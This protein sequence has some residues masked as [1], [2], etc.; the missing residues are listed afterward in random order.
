VISSLRPRACD[1]RRLR[2]SRNACLSRSCLGSFGGVFPGPFSTGAAVCPRS[3]SL[4]FFIVTCPHRREKTLHR[5]NPRAG[6]FSVDRWSSLVAFGDRDP[7]VPLSTE[8][9]VFRSLRATADPR[10]PAA[11]PVL[12]TVIPI[13][14][15]LALSAAPARSRWNSASISANGSAGPSI[16]SNQRSRRNDPVRAHG[17]LGQGPS[18]C[19]DSKWEPA[20]PGTEPVG[21]AGGRDR[22]IC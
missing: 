4:S 6:I 2:F 21:A 20:R 8:H 16:S 22:L 12:T 19:A 1:F 14:E 17:P 9:I 13:F 15:N 18:P 5:R 3:L 7:L 10:W 11:L